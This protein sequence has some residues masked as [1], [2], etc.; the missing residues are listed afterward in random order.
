MAD[1]DDQ[2]DEPLLDDV[3]A[4]PVRPA[5]STPQTRQLTPAR[6]ADPMRLAGQIAVDE[7]A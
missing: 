4:D 5:A 6:L 3:V 1:V 2:D 7:L